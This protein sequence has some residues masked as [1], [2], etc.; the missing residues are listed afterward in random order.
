MSWTVRVSG[1]VTLEATV[2]AN[3]T[4]EIW[5]PGQQVP[6]Q[7]APAPVGATFSRMASFDGI[8]YAVYEAGSGTYRFNSGKS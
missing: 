1:T 2:P 7:Q 6:G 8:Q 3:T 5:V 4:A